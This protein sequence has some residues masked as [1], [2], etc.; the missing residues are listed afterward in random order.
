MYSAD[1]K[2]GLSEAMV[3]GFDPNGVTGA[4]ADDLGNECDDLALLLGGI[5]VWTAVW[6]VFNA[7]VNEAPKS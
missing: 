1:F 2:S 5:L 6:A 7:A 4:L 3:E